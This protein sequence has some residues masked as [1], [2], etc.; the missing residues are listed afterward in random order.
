M[1]S[2]LMLLDA[3]DQ[4]TI[5]LVRRYLK[6]L[7]LPDDRLRVT[8]SK[9][10]FEAWLGRRIS[11]SVGGAYVFLRGSGEHAV[12]INLPR[13]NRSQAKALEIVV[14]EELIHY[15]DALDGDHRR[16]RKHGY[17]RIAARVATLTGASFAEVRSALLP[18]TRRPF[19]YVYECTA[20]RRQV[21]RRIRGT[22]S[23]GRCSQ[24]FDRRFVLRLVGEAKSEQAAMRTG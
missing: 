15:R 12:L 20:C 18:A 19:R 8:T 3:T 4:E 17:D 9:P 24:R 6:V 13:I 16:H 11:S 14:A 2:R 1:L 23:C 21:F 5:W 7:R 22:W 10:T